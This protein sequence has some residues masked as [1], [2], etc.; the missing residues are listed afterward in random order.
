M[1]RGLKKTIAVWLIGFGLGTI[2]VLLLP[3]TWWLVI[4]GIVVIAIGIMWLSC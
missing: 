1:F 2:M 4:V 3:V